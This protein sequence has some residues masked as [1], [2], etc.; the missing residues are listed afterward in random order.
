M[1]TSDAGFFSPNYETARRRFRSAVANAGLHV[2]THTI[3]SAGP[4]GID[5]SLDAAIAGNANARQAMVLSSG[6]HGVEGFLG[7]AIQLAVL[8]QWLPK[9]VSS[10][11][12]KLILIHA[13]NPFG[14]AWRRRVNE[15]N[16]DPN[17]NFLLPGEPYQGTPSAYQNLEAFLNP[18]RPPSRLDKPLFLYKAAREIRRHGMP[19]LK[20]AVAGGQ[21]DLPQGLFFGGHEPSQLVHILDHRLPPWL[22]NISSVLHIDFHTGLGPWATYKLL[23]DAEVTESRLEW[24]RAHFDPPGIEDLIGDTATRNVAYQTRGSL[25]KWC[26]AKMS[27]CD[28]LFLG[29]EFGTYGAVKVLAGLRAENQAHHWGQPQATSTKR[30]KQQ[31]QELFFPASSTWQQRTLAQGTELVMKAAQALTDG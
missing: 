6:L 16:V 2:E 23:L 9:I 21:Y 18:K 29:A 26:Q 1:T 15:D 19:A 7:S 25:G 20:Q 3:A 4:D 8:E 12:L 28:Y 31:L 30:A 11:P 17:R 10:V 24:L 14:F 5:L 13:L 27:P 22:D